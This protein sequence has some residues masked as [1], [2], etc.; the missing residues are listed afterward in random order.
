MC[1]YAI[2]THVKAIN[3]LLVAVH[4]SSLYEWKG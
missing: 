4:G 1:N 3:E 2:K